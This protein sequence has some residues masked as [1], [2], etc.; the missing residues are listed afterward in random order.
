[1]PSPQRVSGRVVTVLA[2][3]ASIA[4]AVAPPASYY[5]A[6]KARLSGALEVSARLQAG[7]VAELARRNPG[8]WD[9]GGVFVVS[10]AQEGPDPV[11]EHRRVRDALGRVV[12]ETRD[13][14]PLS[15]PVLTQAAPVMDG[16]RRLGSV[17]ASRSLRPMLEV[18]AAVAVLAVGFGLLVFAILRVLPLRLL[19]RALDRATYLATHDMLTGLPNRV[20]FTERLHALLDPANKAGVAL[21]C[22][23]LDR[24]KEV[25]DTLGHTAGDALL[26]EVAARMR[27]LLAPDELLA[28]LGGD[29]FA[30]LVPNCNT[31]AATALAARLCAAME[32]VFILGGHRAAIAVSIGAAAGSGEKG[33]TGAQ[34]LIDADVALYEAKQAG[35]GQH[36]LFRPDMHRHLTD[37]LHLEADLRAAVA[38]SGFSLHYQPITDLQTGRVVAAEALLRW[39]RPGHGPVPPDQ[40]VPVAEETG[41]ISVIGGWALTEACCQAATWPSAVQVAVNISATQLRFPGLQEAISRALSASGLPPWRLVLEIT[42]TVLLTDTSHVLRTLEE[43]QALGIEVAMDDF[44]TGYSS[45]GYLQRFHFNKLKIDQRFV[46]AIGRDRRSEAIIRAIL[47]VAAALGVQTTAEGVELPEQL[48]FLKAEGCQQVQGYLLGRPMPAAAFVARLKQPVG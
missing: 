34:L 1:M 41:L 17:E 33:T 39:D 25:N 10:A 30:V 13:G 44:G 9:L 35:R 28:R 19:R 27:A 22:L 3:I 24:F 15:W 16:D 21:L 32:P 26:R 7:E 47:G 18:T 23:D 40:F 12:I 43:V 5:W 8:F 37:R 45:L 11:N 46:Q 42:E 20:L 48:A 2:A 6:A 14:S 31:E 36:R 29:E 4:I 38:E